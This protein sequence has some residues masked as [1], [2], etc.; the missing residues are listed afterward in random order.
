[1]RRI[2]PKD[3][4]YFEEFLELA[5]S[6]GAKGTGPNLSPEEMREA[7]YEQDLE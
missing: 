2:K 4:Q 5:H 1:M 7:L 3:D 6:H